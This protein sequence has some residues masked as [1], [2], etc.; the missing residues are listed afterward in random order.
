MVCRIALVENV[1]ETVTKFFHIKIKIVD[2][3]DMTDI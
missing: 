1:L 2:S 3:P